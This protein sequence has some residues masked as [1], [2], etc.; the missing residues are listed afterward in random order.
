MKS[1]PGEQKF[2]N[3]RFFS[4]LLQIHGY[5]S[6]GIILADDSIYLVRVC[7]PDPI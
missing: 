1:F 2:F 5:K 4:I 3:I 6:I 7:P